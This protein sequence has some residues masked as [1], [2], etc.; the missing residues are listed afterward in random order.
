MDSALLGVLLGAVAAVAGGLFTRA[1]RDRREGRIAARLIL[2]ELL[3]NWE[4][5]KLHQAWVEDAEVPVQHFEHQ[6][7]VRSWHE[8]GPAFARIAPEV[9]FWTVYRAFAESVFD[10]KHSSDSGP[11]I[12]PGYPPV[13]SVED[14][15]EAMEQ[16]LG[17]PA[18]WWWWLAFV[19]AGEDRDLVGR[20]RPGYEHPLDWI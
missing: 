8:H 6:W 18:W 5:L 17:N 14:A 19:R 12:T 13:W 11:T 16:I 20:R 9:E 10:V 3:T 1:W 15:V 2:G 7:S 4:D